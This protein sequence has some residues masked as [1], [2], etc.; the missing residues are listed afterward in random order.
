MCAA[1]RFGAK[2]LSPSV[3]TGIKV[4]FGKIAGVETKQGFISTRVVVNAAGAYASRVSGMLGC[5]LP[6]A[7]IRYQAGIFRRPLEIETPHPITVDRLAGHFYFRPDERGHT[8]VGGIG[9]EKWLD[10]ENYNETTDPDYSFNVLGLL[11]KRIPGME[12]AVFRGG[13]AACDGVSDDEYAIIDKISEVEGFY[14]AVGHSGHGFK[15]APAVGIC[16]AELITEGR[17][18]TVNI[19]SFR[20]SRFAEGVNP[21]HNPN[22]YGERGQ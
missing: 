21:F 11:E 14:C 7:P 6:V 12:R 3:V 2:L 13:R 5:S 20:L 16:M 15:I 4:E 8:L 9:A 17:A 10:P 22:L 18:K 19:S 1:E